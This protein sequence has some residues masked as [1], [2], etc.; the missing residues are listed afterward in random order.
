[1]LEIRWSGGAVTGVDRRRTIGSD[2]RCDTQLPDLATV[3]LLVEAVGSWALVE[4]VTGE[5][6][7]TVDGDPLVGRRAVGDQSV[8]T[9]GPHVGR[10]V[11]AGHAAVTEGLLTDRQLEVLACLGDGD[12]MEEAAARLELATN[13]VRSH[14]QAA[15]RRLD[16]G[17]R[18]EALGVLF[19]RGILPDR[20]TGDAHPDGLYAGLLAQRA[21]DGDELIIL[22][23][24]F[25]VWEARN[26]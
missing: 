12:T 19:A 11:T 1:M 26:S 5:A 22:P 23:P 10:V 3:Q 17:S 8:L 21:D 4:D 7:T 2:E 20:R 13:T 9:V 16:V 6:G 14:V 25:S 24:D 18:S 15:Y